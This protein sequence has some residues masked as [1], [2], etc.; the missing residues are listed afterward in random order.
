MKEA[1]I[2]IQPL[3]DSVQPRQPVSGRDLIKAPQPAITAP[4]STPYSGSFDNAAITRIQNT[5]TRVLDIEK[6]LIRLNLLK[7]SGTYTGL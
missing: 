7:V 3:N 5:E 1:S 6:V 2:D 4:D